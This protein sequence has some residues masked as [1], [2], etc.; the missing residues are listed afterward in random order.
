MTASSA[1][2]ALCEGIE[3]PPM[4]QQVEAWAHINSGSDNLAGMARMAA[5]LAEA[6]AALPAEPK[7]LVPAPVERIDA[8][9]KTVPVECGR[10]LI[11]QV[12]PDA[13]RRVLLTGHMDTVYGAEQRFQTCCW[14]D[15]ATLQGPGTADMKGGLALMLAALQAFET[16]GP[17]LG[18]DVLI[19]S[20][21]EIGSPSSAALIAELAAGKLAALTY[22]P[23]LP[24]GRMARARPGSGNFSAIMTGRAAHA[25]RNPDEGRN[26][27]VAAGDF[28]V[29][30]AQ[31]RSGTLLINPARIDGGGGN[32]V[33]PALAIVRFNV[34]PVR[35]EDQAQAEALIA[36]TASAI[37]HEHQVSV[38]IHGTFGRPP[39]P[40]SE[41]TVRL[42]GLLT[43]T[44]ADLGE[45]L[46]WADTG[47]VCD[48]NNI[49]A[50][51]VPVI[52]TLGALG[53]AIHSPDEFLKVGSLL[54]RARLSA[55]LLHRLDQGDFNR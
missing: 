38:H 30:L 50:C 7:L 43:R 33:V 52:D 13:S 44:G 14:L 55:V 12:R 28:A 10:H 54:S 35:P 49:A 11:V 17:S 4:I 3:L 16:I 53:G 32:N 31:A 23:A 1:E 8:A 6:F 20:D 9:G 36:S 26:A 48:G 37:E 47:G 21:E 25:G 22:E 39:K 41:D 40:I 45:T 24:D 46:A 42:F 18:Y 15:D 29:R 51:G 27:V 2:Q 19:N 34:R 5:T